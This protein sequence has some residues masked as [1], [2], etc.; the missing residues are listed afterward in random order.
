MIKVLY[1][2]CCT[3]LTGLDS[4]VY[5]IIFRHVKLSQKR[6]CFEIIEVDAH[7]SQ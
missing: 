3:D 5:D 7:Q 2:R 4:L 6:K 1:E